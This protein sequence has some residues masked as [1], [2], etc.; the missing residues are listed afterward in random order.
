MSASRLPDIVLNNGQDDCSYI[1]GLYATAKA[2]AGPNE[3]R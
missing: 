2:V 3:F 1:S